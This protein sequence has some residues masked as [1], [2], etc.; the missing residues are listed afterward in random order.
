MV[1]L[2]RRGLQRGDS[3]GDAQ[4]IFAVTNSG[5]LIRID[6]ATGTSEELLPRTPFVTEVGGSARPGSIVRLYGG[7]FAEAT[8][9]PETYPATTSLAGVEVELQGKP[10]IITRVSPSEIDFQ[11]PWDLNLLPQSEVE[12]PLLVKVPNQSPLQLAPLKWFYTTATV[13]LPPGPFREDGTLVT[14]ARRLRSYEVLRMVVSGVSL[15]PGVNGMP[16]EQQQS[17]DFPCY[18]ANYPVGRPIETLYAGPLPG[19][20]GLSEVVVKLT[21]L[22]GTQLDVGRRWSTITCGDSVRRL[23]VTLP[24][25]KD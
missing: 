22:T 18:I 8:I 7:G 11:T 23:G 3:S 5:R 19:T 12:Y 15:P 24:V 6:R 2:F 13:L 21:D 9:Q 10:M 16:A 17:V 25:A 14:L 1:R 20:V 4:V